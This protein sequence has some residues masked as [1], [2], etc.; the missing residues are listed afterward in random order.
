MSNPPS[1][2]SGTS[3]THGPLTGTILSRTWVVGPLLG[4]GA[5]CS[6]VYACS[7]VSDAAD[8]SFDQWVVKI[9][10]P[11]DSVSRKTKRRSTNQIAADALFYEYTIYNSHLTKFRGLRRVP[12]LPPYTA[13][14]YGECKTSNVRYL[15]ISRLNGYC[16]W[17]AE[18]NPTL[19]NT[20]LIAIEALETLRLFHESH[21]VYVDVKPENI[22]VRS[23]GGLDR[24]RLPKFVDLG[25]V[26][27]Y[28]SCGR[29]RE[30]QPISGPVVGTPQ[31]CSIHVHRGST[32]S[33]RDDV[34]AL[35]YVLLERVLAILSG[36]DA[37]PGSGPG[38]GLHLLPWSDATSD[39]DG[40]AKKEQA[41]AVLIR[42]ADGGRVCSDSV[43]DTF[44]NHPAI[45]TVRDFIR[46]AASLDY[47]SKPDYD[48]LTEILNGTK[49]ARTTKTNETTTSEPTATPTRSPKKK[50]P[51]KAGKT[52]AAIDVTAATDA[53]T[54]VA[55]DIVLPKKRTP[56]KAT[57]AVVADIAGVDSADNVLLPK[58]R[59]PTKATMVTVTDVVVVDASDIVLPTKATAAAG[60]AAAQIL[61]LEVENGPHTGD[62]YVFPESSVGIDK[63]IGCGGANVD[64]VL[65][66]ATIASCHCSATL[67]RGAV[68]S[69]R[70]RDLS[71]AAA[72]STGTF[73]GTKRL[74]PSRGKSCGCP[75][76][77]GDKFTI[78]D[79]TLLVQMM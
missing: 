25:L 12:D 69:L 43:F 6:G 7:K 36:T 77:D 22:M 11:L 9:S 2:G 35:G 63:T 1:T 46:L 5:C 26:S 75:V 29:H 38:S 49:L 60:A 10:P 33:R 14:G 18:A 30:N 8:D 3:D 59:T 61:F 78:G 39:K 52:T 55:T 21:I 79:I 28:T 53:T 4:S 72:A 31:Y 34:E 32:P 50:T 23:D 68:W 47:D 42:S 13:R 19:A 64:W 16:D 70:I 45:Q 48:G 40:L 54:S 15:V 44:I 65:P 73:V 74:Q 71:T 66:K 20:F 24:D 27:F 62:R 58:K 51:T 37:G 67:H 17:G 76:F 57:V 56:T 41:R